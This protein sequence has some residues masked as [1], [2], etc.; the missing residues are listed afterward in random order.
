MADDGTGTAS[1]LGGRASPHLA[2][3]EPPPEP[4]EGGRD[5]AP[6]SV[7]ELRDTGCVL[8]PPYP[9]AWP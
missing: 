8:G 3:P 2:Q 7:C 5:K 9:L 6:A 4:G 1:E